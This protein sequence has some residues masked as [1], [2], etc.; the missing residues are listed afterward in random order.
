[1]YSLC[2]LARASTTARMHVFVDNLYLRTRIGGGGDNPGRAPNLY[3]NKFGV[4]MYVYMYRH[5][6]VPLRC[7][8]VIL[9]QAGVIV[10]TNHTQ[11]GFSLNHDDI[12][13]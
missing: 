1:M 8:C 2:T 10:M 11:A 9:G 6:H 4:S 7:P 5:V 13:D 3:Y 12:V